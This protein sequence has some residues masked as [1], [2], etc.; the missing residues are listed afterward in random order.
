MKV[1]RDCSLAEYNTFGLDAKARYFVE[2]ESVEELREWL[3][4]DMCRK[5]KVLHIGRGSNLLLTKD[6]D[7]VVLHSGIR[8]TEYT[9]GER[10]EVTARVGSGVVW[11]DFCGDAA[12]RG[13]WGVE[14]LSYIPGEVGAS[15]VQNIGAYGVEVCDV[16]VSVEVIDR[17]DGG[18]RVIGVGEC[19]YG[20]RHSRFKTEWRERYIVTAVN[21][22]LSRVAQPR[23]EYAGLAALKDE[24]EGLTA[25]RVREYVTEIR[26]TKLPD[27]RETGSAGSFFKNPVIERE[28]YEMLLK[29]YPAMPHYAVD[30]G[31][32]KVPA[33]WLIEQCGW[34]GRKVGDAQVYERQPLV[35]VNAGGATAQDIMTLAQ[36]VQE[37]VRERF[38]IEITPEVNYI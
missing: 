37:S 5:E 14:N 31:G 24:G 35:I 18:V 32:V 21:Y 25:R 20:Y 34:K 30:G 3:A 1:I 10:G 23:L 33:A 19:D 2:Y 26:R 11:D 6:F 36:R 12:E 8:F 9:E 38:G 16:I 27:P 22:R 28:R 4:S 15:A 7:G 29:S 13:L 17:R